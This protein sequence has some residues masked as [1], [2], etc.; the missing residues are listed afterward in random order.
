MENITDHET[1]KF[2]HYC[3]RLNN[4]EL[5]EEFTANAY[6]IYDKRCQDFELPYN[7]YIYVDHTYNIMIVEL[8]NNIDQRYNIYKVSNTTLVYLLAT[9]RSLYML[10]YEPFNIIRENLIKE[11]KENITL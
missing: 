8:Y 10:D 4:Y 1:W 7:L 11:L 2:V 5:S 3:E 6:R 9:T